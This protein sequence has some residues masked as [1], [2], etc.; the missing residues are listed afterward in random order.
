MA[1]V[2]TAGSTGFARAANAGLQAAMAGGWALALLLN[3]DAAPEAG[4]VDA[5]REAWRP[6]D[7]ALGP[8]LLNAEG[9]VESAGLRLG[10]SGW[11][12]PIRRAPA[13]ATEVEGLSGAAL[14]LRAEERFDPAYAHGFEDLA[15]CRAL[16]ARGFS[17][18]VVPAARCRHQGGATLPRNSED[19][20]RHAVSG[21]LRL[22]NS[23]LRA[24]LA[25]GLAAAQVLREGG[26]P[27]RLRGIWRGYQD[28]R[29]GPGG[30]GGIGQAEDQLG[31]VDALERMQAEGLQRLP[32]ELGEGLAGDQGLLQHRGQ[33]VEAG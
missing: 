32:A 21:H 13:E 11:L 8:V 15:L 26:P 22:L 9:A 1:V 23:R 18:R 5:L 20:Q 4:C 30:A 3:D 6:T 12:R 33:R 25:L 29:S 24:P 16:R 17:V 28:W 7:G 31:R 19:A 2:R 10:R 14:L 27:R